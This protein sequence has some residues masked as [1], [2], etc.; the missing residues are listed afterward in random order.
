MILYIIRH[1]ETDWNVQHKNQG[2]TDIPLNENGRRLAKITGDALKSVRFDLIISSPLSRAVETARIITKGTNIPLYEDDRIME[3]DWGKWEGLNSRDQS[4]EAM[5][6]QLRLYFEKPWEF[7]GAPDG[8]NMYQVYQRVS[9]FCSELSRDKKMKDKTVLLSTHGTIV[10]HIMNYYLKDED[11]VDFW[12]GAFPRN[13][14]VSI[15][16]VLNQET[17]LLMKDAF[18]YED[19]MSP[20]YYCMDDFIDE[21]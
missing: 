3:I 18:Y 2:V 4:I 17:E 20:D 1:G 7:S 15:L 8:E 5:Q 6:Y 14:S 21:A 9:Q 12:R 19:S 10:R 16:K 11:K 13:C